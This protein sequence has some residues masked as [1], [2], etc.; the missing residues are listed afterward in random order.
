MSL[1]CISD[2]DMIYIYIDTH[3]FWVYY[4]DFFRIIGRDS[5]LVKLVTLQRQVIIVQVIERIRY[6]KGT[7]LS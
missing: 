6:S 7:K 4:F 1:F 3:N 5:S 2:Y